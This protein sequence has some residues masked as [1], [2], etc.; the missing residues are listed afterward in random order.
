MVL[1]FL[2]MIIGRVARL[3]G[4]E[5]SWHGHRSKDITGARL[6]KVN[7]REGAPGSAFWYLGL[8]LDFIPPEFC[9][10]FHA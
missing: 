6:A 9:F 1:N 7:Y 2:D 8:G 4:S 10:P 5:F 3:H